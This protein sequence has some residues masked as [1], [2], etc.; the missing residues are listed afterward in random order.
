MM[1]TC[2][3]ANVTIQKVSVQKSESYSPGGFGIGGEP[4]SSAEW[5][6]LFSVAGQSAL[7]RFDNVRDGSVLTVNRSFLVDL[8]ALESLRIEVSGVE[9]DDSSANDPLPTA[10]TIIT[11][12]ANWA[13]GQ[14]FDV[15]APS[16]ED[17]AY[18]FTCSIRCA[19]S[20][21]AFTVSPSPSRQELAMQRF[22]HL[23]E[24]ASREGFIGAFPNFYEATYGL[25][26]VGG[27]IFV[28]P[29]VAEWRDVP[30]AELGNP[31][32][33]DFGDRMRAVNAYASRNGF[34]GG[35]PNFFH[36]ETSEVVSITGQRK[37][38]TV[39]GTV[40]LNSNGAEWRDVPLSELGNPALD[41][42]E[43]RFRA[44]QDYATRNGFVGGFPNLFH[45]ET[46]EVSITGQRKRIT[47]CG[48]VLLK[49]DFAEW[50]DVLIFR[51]PA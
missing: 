48:T 26:H 18:S 41:D 30:L 9:I 40:L 25:D 32:L 21:Q 15:A 8:G 28:K 11:P 47:V 35:F 10:T 42:F 19:S 7:I 34:V 29:A 43:A 44:T 27:T 23:A 39:C 17:F 24:V 6:L 45:A 37:R 50:R 22:R 33:G 46:T 51:G 16:S 36:A 14:T 49:P 3:Q 13:D 12:A 38:I 5:Q 4:G 1:A 20:A 31:P 2:K